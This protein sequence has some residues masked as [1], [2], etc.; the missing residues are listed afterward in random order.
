M[1]TFS[2]S[3]GKL[4]TAN[5]KYRYDTSRQS[6]NNSIY[7]VAETIKEKRQRLFN[8]NTGELNLSFE[9]V[10]F[11]IFDYLHHQIKFE[12]T[13]GY[14]CFAHIIGLPT[15]KKTGEPSPFYPYEEEWFRALFER[16][17]ANPLKHIKKWKHVMV[18]KATG[19]GFTDF[20]VYVMIYL[21]CAYPHLF[22]DS[23]MAIVTGIN[24]TTAKRIMRRM[25][26]LIWNKLRLRVDSNDRILDLNGCLIE[27][28][29]AIKP[30]TYR[31]LD[32]CKFILYDEMDFCPISLIEEVRDAIERYFG[33]SDPWVVLGSTA[34]EPDGMMERLE[35]QTE[36]ECMYKR[37]YSLVDKGRG[38]IF[39]ERDLDVARESDSYP[40]EYEGEYRGLKG[41]LFSTELLEFCAGITDKLDILDRNTKELKRTIHRIEND[42]DIEEIVINPDYLGKN[43]KSS[44]GCDPAWESSIFAFIVNKR[45]GNV[46]YAVKELEI[47]SPIIEESLEEAK[48]LIYIDYPTRNPKFYV[49][50]SPM[51]IPFIRA[52]KKE[53]FEDVNYHKIPELERIKLIESPVGMQVCPI[54]FNKYGDRMNFNLRRLMEAGLY[55]VSPDITPGYWLSLTTAQYD[56]NKNRFAKEKT[57]KNDLFDAGRLAAINWRVNDIG[58]L[59]I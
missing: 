31:A 33:K 32:N 19:M 36:E 6:S 21:P 34:N 38:Y 56:A 46:V 50:S 26:T 48:D 23:Q 54:S 57:S 40:R 51:S 43:Y 10:P 22:K 2:K 18:K 45:V 16:N 29:P 28:F 3:L 55:R 37:I 17:F 27:C 1:Q 7:Q 25:K 58:V 11:W 24:M 59:T 44:Y 47:Q 9:D 20:L 13:N 15:N 53:M 8:K 14:C 49:D 42:I 4:S 41:N 5:S 39:S 35:K 12:L 52:L 30:D